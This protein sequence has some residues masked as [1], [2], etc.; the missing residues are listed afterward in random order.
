MANAWMTHLKATMKRHPKL[1]LS[2][3]MKEAK[4]TYHKSKTHKGGYLVKVG[5][6]RR[7]TMKGGQLYGFGEN[8]GT[9][10][11]GMGRMTQVESVAD[12]AAKTTVPKTSTGGSRRRRHTRRR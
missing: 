5:G 4:K 11:D 2:E 8:G 6:K 10:S 9:L 12:I 3:A 7:K 1:S